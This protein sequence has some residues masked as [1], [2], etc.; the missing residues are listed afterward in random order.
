MRARAP[1]DAARNG[2]RYYARFRPVKKRP[3]LT[4][5]A[6]ARQNRQRAGAEL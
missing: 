4:N 2:Q 3:A 1:V 5:R 6:T